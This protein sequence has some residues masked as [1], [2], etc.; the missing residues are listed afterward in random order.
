LIF[1]SS[2]RQSEKDPT[3]LPSTEPQNQEPQLPQSST[4][5]QTKWTNLSTRK[6]I[7]PQNPAKRPTDPRDL[8]LPCTEPAD[9]DHRGTESGAPHEQ[10][11]NPSPPDLSRQATAGGEKHLNQKLRRRRVGSGRT[12]ADQ[13]GEAREFG[14]IGGHGLPQIAEFLVLF[15]EEE[16]ALKKWSFFSSRLL[17]KAP[18]IV[19]P[20]AREG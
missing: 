5:T 6:R 3:Q 7:N 14:R 10:A 13:L 8:H 19:I 17:V 4:K 20:N 2:K 16:G 1:G 18:K 12:H 15:R 11:T 9:A